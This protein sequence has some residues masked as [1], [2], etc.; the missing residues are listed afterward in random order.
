MRC[1]LAI[2]VCCMMMQCVV[3]TTLAQTLDDALR[4]TQHN[5]LLTARTAALGLA[6]HGIADDYSALYTNPAGLTL[7][8]AAEINAGIQGFVTQSQAEYF[9][10]RTSFARAPAFSFGHIGLA[11]PIRQWSFTLAIGYNRE[12][13]FSAIDTL[14]GFNPSSS[15]VQSWV[16]QQR[17]P[18]LRNNPG[19]QLSLADTVRGQ[20]LSPLTGNLTQAAFILQGGSMSNFSIGGAFDVSQSEDFTLSVGATLIGSF[21]GYTYERTYQ[22]IDETGRYNRLDPVN[23]TNIDFERL[24]IVE[25]IRQSIGGV[26]GV[27]G[28][29]ARIGDI[30]RLGF[31]AVT[32]GS[33]N[34]L[35]SFVWNSNAFFEQGNVRSTQYRFNGDTEYSFTTPWVIQASAAAHYLG[36]TLSAAI[37]YLDPTQVRFSSPVR[38]TSTVAAQLN[39]AAAR[40]LAAQTQW[41]L[42][43]EYENSEL[44]VALRGSITTI[45][46]PYA[47]PEILSAAQIIGLGAGY[48]LSSNM[49]LDAVVRWF[50]RTSLTL[51]DGIAS[52]RGMQSILQFGLQVVYRF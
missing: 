35:E 43:V 50:D 45:A 28:V 25:Q 42:G 33:Y 9:G 24:S 10:T 47:Q 21:G 39:A 20:F 15:I 4:H 17:G 29:Q 22:E 44:P 51:V 36:L 30:F 19:W 2:T 26:R 34:V 37:E 48:Y 14:R 46:S 7:L 1:F 16:R 8:P 3:R 49:R 11:L 27:L 40:V 32:P 6:Y 12:N 18:D 38:S 31:S 13:E 41:G 5:A 52:Y 23:F